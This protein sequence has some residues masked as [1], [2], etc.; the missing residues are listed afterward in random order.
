MRAGPAPSSSSACGEA[1]AG[2]HRHQVSRGFAVGQP[3]DLVAL[4][5]DRGDAREPALTFAGVVPEV[6]ALDLLTHRPDR[7]LM[8]DADDLAPRRQVTCGRHRLEHPL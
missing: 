1:L 2:L 5:A 6:V 7:Q 3:A 4:V 8:A